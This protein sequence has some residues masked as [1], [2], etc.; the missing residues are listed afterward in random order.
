M[1]LKIFY[2]SNFDK[3]LIGMRCR[4]SHQLRKSLTHFR[5]IRPFVLVVIPTVDHQINIT[6]IAFISFNCMQRRT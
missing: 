3:L 1:K 4:T 6:D 2:L 5:N